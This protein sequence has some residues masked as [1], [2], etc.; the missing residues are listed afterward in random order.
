MKKHR[1]KILILENGKIVIEGIPVRTGQ[2]VEVTVTIDEEIPRTVYPL[3]GLPVRY[4]EPFLPAV[5]ES[6]WDA[7]K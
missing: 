1:Y 2:H 4:D 6:D 7:S 5:P 3:R